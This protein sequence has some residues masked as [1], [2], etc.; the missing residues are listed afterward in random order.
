MTASIRCPT[1]RKE[2]NGRPETFPFC[3]QRCRDVDLG[4]WFLER[5]TISRPLGPDDD[6]ELP[7]P[8]DEGSDGGV[9]VDDDESA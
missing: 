2:L 4:N 3:S 5:Y 7:E 8:E 1:C 6:F 9:E